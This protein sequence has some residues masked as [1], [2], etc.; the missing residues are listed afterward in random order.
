MT[1]NDDATMVAYV[2]FV[3]LGMPY[4]LVIGP[5]MILGLL[6]GGWST[7]STLLHQGWFLLCIG[8]L[9]LMCLML[10]VGAVLD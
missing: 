10:I 6:G 1:L 9:V 4:V 2:L 8:T 5:A 7:A 3:F